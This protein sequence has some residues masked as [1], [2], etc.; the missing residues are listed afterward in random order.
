LS[1]TLEGATL[2]LQQAALD[3]ERKVT[4]QN[5]KFIQ[6]VA[7]YVI[8][9]DMLLETIGAMSLEVAALEALVQQDEEWCE[10]DVVANLAAEQESVKQK[11]NEAQADQDRM[12][13]TANQIKEL[14]EGMRLLNDRI[15]QHHAANEENER[16][17]EESKSHF[18]STQKGDD[19]TKKMLIAKV[20]SA[21]GEAERLRSD[22]ARLD[23]VLLGL[24]EEQ[25]AGAEQVETM[26][27]DL[28]ETMQLNANIKTD[29]AQS[30]NPERRDLED[31][32][33]ARTEELKVATDDLKRTSS[34]IKNLANQASSK[35]QEAKCTKSG[36]LGIQESS[37]I[38][39][40]SI[41]KQNSELQG[42]EDTIQLLQS[43]ISS[44]HPVA[45]QFDP[46]DE[47]LQTRHDT[48]SLLNREAHAHA[49]LEER[50]CELAA[51]TQRVTELTNSKEGIVS[52]MYVEQTGLN[53]LKNWDLNQHHQQHQRGEEGEGEG[54]TASSSAA[55]LNLE[56]SQ[57][58]Q[59]ESSSD[60]SGSIDLGVD[61][62]LCEGL[63]RADEA[64]KEAH[65]CLSRKVAD[66]E[67]KQRQAEAND[68]GKRVAAQVT[69]RWKQEQKNLKEMLKKHTDAINLLKEEVQRED[70]NFKANF[71][72]AQKKYE[73]R[74]KLL[75]DELE[76]LIEL[77]NSVLHNTVTR[78]EEQ[79]Q[80]QKQE[81]KQKQ[82]Q[83]QEQEEE[84]EEEEEQEQEKGARKYLF[85]KRKVVLQQ[86]YY[87]NRRLLDQSSPSE[88]DEE[89]VEQSNV[90]APPH[91][92]YRRIAHKTLAHSSAAASAWA[93]P[94]A[95]DQD[96]DDNDDDNE[97]EE[98]QHQQH[99]VA[100]QPRLAR[101]KSEPQHL[102]MP[103]PLSE[104]PTVM[105]QSQSLGPS[106]KK[107]LGGF[108]IHHDANQSWEDSSDDWALSQ[109]HQP[110]PHPGRPHVSVS[111][112]GEAAGDAENA[113]SNTV[114]RNK[115]VAPL[116]SKQQN[117]QQQQ[118]KQGAGKK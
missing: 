78:T 98:Q 7:N 116:K 36:Y 102:P 111:V 11:Q 56:L 69:Q 3:V 79:K 34:Q 99:V 54:A 96:D 72:E 29:H 52:E 74:E 53:R 91:S 90:P 95:A 48:D 55:L 85:S 15:Q 108:Q 40:A 114:R 106:S 13:N 104:P 17:V 65:A 118:Q 63:E 26:T 86:P 115:P 14:V 113:P 88:N 70:L 33:E 30:L 59:G 93:S 12:E 28:E 75:K 24:Q 66:Y 10:Q 45:A 4:V 84:Q 18:A 61:P 57:H 6:D 105:T 94:G 81:K 22:I 25:R 50:R 49:A 41:D 43:A 51:A 39:E 35:E 92:T 68:S 9:K 73:L 42:I 8:N 82:E 109:P 23:Q 67:K 21:Q 27:R 31:K 71:A 103:Q 89:S 80:K 32:L 58:S 5:N 46:T 100:V 38:L 1:E 16:A 110:P 64:M 77:N 76:R 60:W 44:E 47:L 19:K 20:S 62:A 107:G 2:L 37:E 101:R 87:Q 97:D 117:Q 83:E 112:F